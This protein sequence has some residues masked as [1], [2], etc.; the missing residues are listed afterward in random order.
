M[1]NLKFTET[2]PRSISYIDVCFVLVHAMNSG[3]HFTESS[4]ES[5]GLKHLHN[6]LNVR[7]TTHTTFTDTLHNRILFSDLYKMVHGNEKFIPD[8][9]VLVVQNSS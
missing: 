1:I 4:F 7:V 8:L 2:V 6:A 5:V 3:G 9:F